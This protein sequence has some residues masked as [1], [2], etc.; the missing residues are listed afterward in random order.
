MLVVSSMMILS[1]PSMSVPS[2]ASQQT[3]S[4]ILIL[5]DSDFT[6]E[7]G[8]TGGNG[9]PGD[10]YV[11]EGWDIDA[12]TGNGIEIRNTAAPFIIRD[13]TIHGGTEY[14][15][16]YFA[17]VRNGSVWNVAS[18][19]NDYGIVILSSSSLHIA[20]SVVTY[21]F[22]RAMRVEAS[23]DVIIEGTLIRDNPDGLWLEASS[24]IVIADSN[25]TS[26][27]YAGVQAYAS[28][29]VTI[30]NLSVRSQNHGITIDESDNVTVRNSTFSDN[31]LTGLWVVHSRNTTIADNVFFGDG[32]RFGGE[33]LQDFDSH[34]VENNTV[35][36]SPILFYSG[37]SDLALSDLSAGQ[38]LIVNC[39]NVRLA[40]IYLNSTSVGLQIF[41]S[42]GIQIEALHFFE[43]INGL[44]VFGVSNLTFQAGTFVGNR[45]PVRMGYAKG[46]SIQGT[47]FEGN[48]QFAIA[49]SVSSNFSLVENTLVDN[50]GW[51]V[52][53]ADSENLTVR[54][55]L[56]K[57]NTGGIQLSRSTRA[58]IYHNNLTNNERQAMD[59]QGADN[60]WDNGYPGG[61]N[62]WSDYTGIDRCSGP[63]QD[64]CP[65]PDGIGDTPYVTSGVEDR[66]PLA[67]PNTPPKASFTVLPAEGTTSTIFRVDASTSS[68]REDRP[69]DLQVRWDWEDDGLWDI[70][71]TT[72]KT[73]E[74]A[75]SAV[76][77]YTIR[78]EVRDFKGLT[79]MA[80][81]QVRV[82]P[83]TP[84]LALLLVT[85]LKGALS[86]PFKIDATLSFDWEDPR[87]ALEVRFDWE[88]DGAWDTEWSTTKYAE[89]KYPEH[90]VYNL[91]L[92]VRDT[93]GL[94][95][96]TSVQLEVLRPWNLVPLVAYVDRNKTFRIGVPER[97]TVDWNYTVSDLGAAD[98]AAFGTGPGGFPANIVI[99]SFSGVVGESDAFLLQFAQDLIEGIDEASPVSISQS[100][101]IVETVNTRAAYFVARY[102]S[103]PVVQVGG[104][105]A[106]RAHGRIW[107]FI[108]TTISSAAGSDTPL[109]RRVLESFELLPAP[110]MFLSPTLLAGL[111][112]GG[113]VALGVAAWFLYRR[114]R[115]KADDE[116]R[117]PQVRVPESPGRIEW[118]EEAGGE[119]QR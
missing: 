36:G 53:M 88:G 21:S 60:M 29:N 106:S 13:V 40:N 18:T 70:G 32:V 8:V 42:D 105:L 43:N 113:G 69:E 71:W 72:N 19:R 59:I 20:S 44:E 67:L 93:G 104:I 11:I 109:F 15:G 24:D 39:T 98:L 6:P 65:D 89:H 26:N 61:G 55:N 27:G 47:L 102:V 64:V 79:N 77:N 14:S 56:M 1:L 94:T 118:S 68:D 25:L 100:P 96:R 75:Y 90:G 85:P 103:Q 34:E 115:G 23:T 119:E 57:N 37:C 87:E 30:A 62:L 10:P 92:Q 5:G 45:W 112:A 51:A 38:I 16:L 48:D 22:S 78:L 17:N 81:G 76:G 99:V 63:N 9:T 2:L 108:G 7:N 33:T 31:W 84:P 3:R 66:Y 86:K 35:N 83:N 49:V 111:G 54:D 107:A 74:H 12:F 82:V 117:P 58:H 97:W 73:A 4:P 41:F 50:G 114:R 28:R 116:Q 91:T 80:T 95:N 46:V 101:Q 52:Y 110:L